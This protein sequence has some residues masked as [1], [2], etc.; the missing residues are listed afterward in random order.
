[1]IL[2]DIR[3][4]DL[5]KVLAGPFCAM[6]LAD[7]GAEVIKV[8]NPH[9]GGDDSRQF[10]PH[11]NDTSVYF[12]SINRNKKSITLD[13]K[14][15]HGQRLFKDLVREADVVI[16]NFRAG[17][18]DDLGLGYEEL[19]TINSGIIYA[20]SSGFGHSGPYWDRPAYDAVIQGMGGIMS[21]T[22]EKDGSPTRV[23]VSIG[24]LASG[25]YLA[26]GIALALLHRQKTGEGQKVDVAMLDCQ[27]ALLEN[28]ISRYL[29]AGEVPEPIGNRHPSLA[30]FGSFQ[31]SDGYIIIAVGN[32]R[33]WKELCRVLG[34]PEWA[35]DPRFAT[36]SLRV[37][38][39]TALE[40]LLEQKLME[41]SR[42]DWIEIFVE[43]GIPCGPIN[44]IPD[45]VK[46]PQVQARDMIV[47]IENPNDG[48][49]SVSGVP[50][51]LSNTPGDITKTAP[52]LGENTYEVLHA[53]LG[54]SEKEIDRLKNEGIV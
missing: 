16:E 25:L 50:V 6:Q 26:Y 2:S 39:Y 41:K 24:D 12:M 15:S 27:V 33:L 40:E 35:E 31:T 8:E 29:T 53:L 21:V 46:D 23:G 9:T 34:H 7:F 42:R 30:P 54:L 28:H 14:S 11:S 13:L 20:S 37:E 5:T 4:L 44:S 22:G 48:Q 51:K 36:N 10:G 38:N 32:N 1:M 47:E 17:V 3:V 43:S 52:S 18:M 19:K 49:V 45:L